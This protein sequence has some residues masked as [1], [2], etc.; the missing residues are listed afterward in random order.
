MDVLGAMRPK[1]RLLLESPLDYYG[2]NRA[3]MGTI[4]A[5]RKSYDRRNQV[6]EEKIYLPLVKQPL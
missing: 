4:R 6:R 1:C 3:T 5:I 2:P